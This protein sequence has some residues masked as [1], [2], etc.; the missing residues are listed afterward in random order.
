VVNVEFTV[1]APPAVQAP[2]VLDIVK[3]LKPKLSDS[4]QSYH[5]SYSIFFFAFFASV[6]Y[7][8]K[9]ESG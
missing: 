2:P 8:E 3:L 9:Q 4:F 5:F 6:L 7:N 1:T